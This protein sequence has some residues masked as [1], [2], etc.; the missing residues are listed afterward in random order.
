MQLHYGCKR[1]NNTPMFNKLGPDTGYDCINNYA[2]SSEMAD[3]LNALNQSRR[4]SE[5]D[6]LQ[7]EPERQPGHRHDPRL[8]PGF[9]RSCKDSAGFRMVVQRSQD[10]HAGSDDLS[11]QP[12]KPFRIRGNADRLQKLLILYPSRLLPQNSL[13]S[14]RQLGRERRVPGRLRD[15]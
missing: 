5:D 13:Q 11:R 8:L 2:P 3:F 15:T 4:A 7:L 14:D 6:H 10:R 9:H 1:D 12:W